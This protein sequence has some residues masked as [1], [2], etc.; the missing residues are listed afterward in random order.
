M[1]LATDWPRIGG[2]FFIDWCLL[3]FDGECVESRTLFHGHLKIDMDESEN[4]ANG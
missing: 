2:R 3:I 1:N 4:V